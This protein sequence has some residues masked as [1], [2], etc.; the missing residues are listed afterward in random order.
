M[1]SSDNEIYIH[2]YKIIERLG[3][4][5]FST[6]FKGIHRINQKVVALKLSREKQTHETKV[7]AYMNRECVDGVPT[8]FWY[9]RV[10]DNTC[11][12]TTFYETT[13]E[14]H[15]ESIWAN[16]LYPHLKILN[17]CVQ[18]ITLLD[19]VHAAFIVHSDIKPDNFMVNEKKRVVLIDF[20]LSSLYYNVEKDVYKEN[21]PCEH[22]IG[23]PKFAS[24][25]LHAGHS[26]S[27]RDDLMSLV[28]M[29]I[30]L[31]N[32]QIPWSKAQPTDKVQKAQPTE[33]TD[34]AQPTDKVQK[35]QPTEPTDK[36]QPTEPTDKVH[37]LEPTEKAQKEPTDLPLYHVEHPENLKR[38]RLKRDLGQYL[39]N[40]ADT[41]V[42][43]YLIPFFDHVSSLEFGETPDYK[44]YRQMFS[45][46]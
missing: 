18:L 25:N 17:L 33:P 3:K 34:K 11:I 5:A 41:Y 30:S 29:M 28:Y 19:N 2:N 9:G 35:A 10:G 12:A 45:T 16:D 27:P 36:A 4:G 46:L 31:F 39:R 14:S 26:V 40:L 44:L 43:K 7:L 23:S 20:G 22:L 1:T 13:F 21:K 8:L 15:V 6:V 37:P 38:A 32:K 24:F 42:D